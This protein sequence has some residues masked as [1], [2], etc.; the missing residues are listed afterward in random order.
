[1]KNKTIKI[2]NIIEIIIAFIILS[3]ITFFVN[4]NITIRG[5][6]MDDLLNWSWFPGLNFF[7]YAIKFYDGAKRYRPVFDALQYIEYFIV[8][9]HVKWFSI[10]N[11]LLNSIVAT[12]I[13]IFAKKNCKNSI[14]AIS[15]SMFYALSHFSYYQ[16]TQ[17][18]GVL[19]TYSQFF[20]IIILF[21]CITYLENTKYE[22]QKLFTIYLFYFLVAFTHER[23]ICLFP[24]ILFTIIYKQYKENKILFNKKAIMNSA[25]LTFELVIIFTIRI[26]ATHKLIPSGTGGTEVLETFSIGQAFIFA[27]NQVLFIFGINIGPDFLVGLPIENTTTLLKIIIALSILFILSILLIYYIGKIKHIIKNYKSISVMEVFYKDLLYI[28]FIMLCIASSSVTIRVEMRF[29]Y[30]SFTVSMLYLSHIIGEIKNYYSK[31]NINRIIITTYILFICFFISRNYIE[32]QYR[33]TYPKIHCVMDLMRVNSLADLTVY[34]YGIDELKNK[35]VYILY[36]YYQFNSFYEEYFYK[37]YDKTNEGITI[38][39]IPELKDLPTNIDKEK[40][41]ILIEDI[42]NNGYI[43]ITNSF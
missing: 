30:V 36:N 4:K 33:K 23:Y 5:L 11:I 12:F 9:N 1:M 17:V 35:N 42:G 29:V 10:I 21:S 15:I 20:A 34:K 32:L 26:F 39:I 28:L 31:T 38:K 7:E 43:D 40:D 6:Y 2:T 37:T 3:L 25:I 8:G 13:Y 22:Q 24:L 18:I 14:I 16:I 27:I 19:E 41:I